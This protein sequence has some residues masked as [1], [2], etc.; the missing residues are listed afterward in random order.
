MRDTMCAMAFGV[1]ICIVEHYMSKPDVN[2]LRLTCVSFM[3]GATLCI[4]FLALPAE[5]A[6]LTTSNICAAGGAIAFCG[7]LSSGLACTLQNAGQR[8]VSPPVAALVLAQESVFATI[9][10]GLFLGDT[11]SRHQIAGCAL[12]FA[13]VVISTKTLD[14]H[15]SPQ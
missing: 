12:I 13:A 15:S 3:T 1:Q 10:G 6:I 8:L 5:R 4:P 7:F 14:K 2:V 9:L 11:L